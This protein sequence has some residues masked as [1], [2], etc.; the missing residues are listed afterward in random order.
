MTTT[1]M[2]INADVASGTDINT[3]PIVKCILCFLVIARGMNTANQA[4]S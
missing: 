2:T 3:V 1:G 4:S